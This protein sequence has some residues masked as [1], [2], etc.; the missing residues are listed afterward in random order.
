MDLK[1]SAPKNGLY[2]C[3]IVYEKEIEKLEYIPYRQKRIQSFKLIDTDISYS[4]KYEN[5]DEINTLFEQ[6]EE[7]DEIIIIKNGLVTDTSI[8]NV[9]FYNGKEWL[10]PKL[11]LLKGTTRQR[12]LDTA[13]IKTADIPVKDIK[14][15]SKIAIMNA[16]VDFYIIENVIIL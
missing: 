6:R 10:S 8:A 15:Y 2:R 9:C 4:L 16:M 3:R 13:K 11:P 12:Y 5:R 1:L 7:A 14:N